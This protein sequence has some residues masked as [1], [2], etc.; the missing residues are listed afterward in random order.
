[1][2]NKRG[3][4]LTR[5]AQGYFLRQVTTPA[6]ERA[7][8]LRKLADALGSRLATWPKG[9]SKIILVAINSPYGL[10]NSRVDPSGQNSS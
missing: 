8:G 6:A 7:A 10:T 2:K 9:R 4:R 3:Y 1:M 5:L